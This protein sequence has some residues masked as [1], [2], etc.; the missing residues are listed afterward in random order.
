MQPCRA[1]SPAS[2]Y[3][4][5]TDVSPLAGLWRVSWFTGFFNS[6]LG[7]RRRA[8]PSALL[9]RTLLGSCLP[10]PRLSW[11]LRRDLCRRASL[12]FPKPDG[13]PTG[14]QAETEGPDQHQGSRCSHV[15]KEEA[16][17]HHLYILN[18]EDSE[19]KEDDEKRDT[20]WSHG[21]PPAAPRLGISPKSSLTL[22]DTCFHEMWKP[23]LCLAD[24]P[25]DIARTTTEFT[26]C[27]RYQGRAHPPLGDGGVTVSSTDSICLRRS[28]SAP[29]DIVTSYGI[30]TSVRADPQPERRD[31][32]QMIHGARE[33]GIF[34]PAPPPENS[35]NALRGLWCG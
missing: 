18:N 14:K 28:K 5:A 20:S 12:P 22:Q 31:R 1:D 25:A 33:P 8:A 23:K 13:E 32:R 35:W 21:E 4:L 19:N 26:S 3:H 17:L 30:P 24:G 10:G 6:L 15:P 7:L 29:S 34:A 27:A 11:S 2:L 9:P 16:D